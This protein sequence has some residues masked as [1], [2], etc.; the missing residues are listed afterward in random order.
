MTAILRSM[1]L[2]LTGLAVLPAWHACCGQDSAATIAAPD[3]SQQPQRPSTPPNPNPQHA[4]TRPSNM[5]SSS[6]TLDDTVDAGEMDDDM[7]APRR[8]M[9]K[10]NEYR[11][12]HVTF[13]AGL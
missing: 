7:E 9:A 13:R 4:T 3:E 5:A 11:G 2:S 12:P 6:S 10:W 1:L 8:G